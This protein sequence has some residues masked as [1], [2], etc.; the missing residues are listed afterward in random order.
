[1]KGA[2]IIRVGMTLS[3]ALVAAV[4]AWFLWQ[5]YMYSP[6]TRD[7]RVQAKVVR[8]AP[9]VAGRVVRVAVADNEKV[10][11]GELLFQIDPARY[12]NAVQ[13]ARA[14]LEAAQANAQAAAA[15]LHVDKATAEAAQATYHMRALEARRRKQ[16]GA[17]VSQ[18]ALADAQARA[19]AAK[20]KWQA[21]QARVQRAKAAQAQAQAAVQQAQAALALAQL[22]LKRTRVRAPMDGYV[23]NLNVYVG[24]YVARGQGSLALVSSD[25]FWIYG[26]FEETKLSRIDVGDAVDIQLMSGIDATGHVVSIAR[27]IATSQSPAGG[28]LLAQVEPSFSWVRLAQR[29]PVRISIDAASL[30][31]DA[32]L[33]AGMTATVI[34]QPD[35]S[36]E[37][38]GAKQ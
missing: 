20:A 37:P 36:S 13:Q 16:V 24:D 12:R 7:A 17:A 1:M 25:G 27:A 9:D 11:K 21:A 4:L 8:V 3:V 28:S 10:A 22:K 34:V 26:Y 14:D 5:N 19:A 38:V 15:S 29:I 23:T 35:D 31:D 18:E 2:S 6:W 30:P 33:V 32:H